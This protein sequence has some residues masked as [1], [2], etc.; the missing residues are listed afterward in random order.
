MGETQIGVMFHVKQLQL[1]E[2]EYLLITSCLIYRHNF[3]DIITEQKKVEIL[4]LQDKIDKVFQ[5][6]FKAE[7]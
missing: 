5:F 1:T 2:N 7:D 3:D 6:H 4:A